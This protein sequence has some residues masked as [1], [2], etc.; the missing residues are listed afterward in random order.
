MIHSP[1]PV[2]ES[3]LVNPDCQQRPSQQ[4][5]QTHVAEIDAVWEAPSLQGGQRGQ[6]ENQGDKH[7]PQHPAQ[8]RHLSQ[9]TSHPPA[10]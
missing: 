10:H 3:P 9:L 1:V 2:G 6:P 7:L 8:E 4:G 5:A